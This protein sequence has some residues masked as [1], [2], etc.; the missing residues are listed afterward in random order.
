VL[1]ATVAACIANG[2]S[3]GLLEPRQ[4]IDTLD[5]LRSYC[6]KPSASAPAT[7]AWLVSH[8]FL[9]KD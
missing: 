7:N 5:D 1:D 8:G 9:H 3:Y 6:R 2:L 4:D